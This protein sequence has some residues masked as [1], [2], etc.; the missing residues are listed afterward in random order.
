M[1]KEPTHPHDVAGRKGDE[2]VDLCMRGGVLI[3]VDAGRKGTEDD[4]ADWF[5]WGEGTGQYVKEGKRQEE[6]KIG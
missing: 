6:G 1:G 4:F 2:D 5:L 3:C